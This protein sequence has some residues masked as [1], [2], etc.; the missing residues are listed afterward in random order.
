MSHVVLVLPS[1]SY[2]GPDFVSA[3]ERLGVTLT[4]ASDDPPPLGVRDTLR[5][6]LG[7]PEAAGQHIAAYAR[8]RRA[9]AVVGTD[10][11]SIVAAAVAAAELGLPGN[12]PAAAAATR[13][14]AIMRRLLEAGGVPQPA[15][16]DGE[17]P[18]R[19]AA[20]LGFPAV[21]KPRGMSG[22]RGVIRV[23]DEVE[24]AE[25]SDRIRAIIAEAGT[26]PGILVEEYVPGVEV[27]VEGLL[28][29][30]SL[31]VL[32]V[33]DKPDPLS[34][35]FFEETIYV[36]PSRLPG[37]SLE[38]VAE[39]VERACRALGLSFGP[40]HAEV[41][42]DGEALHVIEVAARTIG[43][44]CS[45]ALR[46]GM[47]GMP[48]EELVLRA[49]LGMKAGDRGRYRPASGVLMLPVPAAGV[50][51]E[52][53]GRETVWEVP[54]I[55]G[56]ETTIPTGRQVRPLPE[57]DRYL[58]FLFAEADTPEAVEAA[59]REAH[60]GLEIVVGT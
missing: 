60:A 38:R 55:V 37:S 24:A 59:L 40:V 21:M 28:A 46:F 47:L 35:P 58:G 2:R 23:N 4:L 8:R 27:A 17:D 52:V 14:K 51:R 54:G 3:A 57:G 22:S 50:L 32:A 48:L 19:S 36:T 16:R 31:E 25:A 45:R 20:A 15:F 42:I 6:D 29:P 26:D 53:R 7:R 5:V 12:E 56:L 34:G 49:A 39:L 33:F 18:R 13:D 11:G 30:E 9:D 41:R 43:G 10:D 44:L 1:S